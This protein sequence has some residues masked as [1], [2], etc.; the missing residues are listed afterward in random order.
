[1]SVGTWVLFLSPEKSCV[2][3][4]PFHFSKRAASPGHFRFLKSRSSS[5]GGTIDNSPGRQ[6][7]EF[8]D[9]VSEAPVGATQSAMRVWCAL[10]WFPGS[11]LGT[12]LI[13]RLGL[14]PRRSLGGRAFPGGSLGTRRVHVRFQAGAWE[15]EGCTCVS[16]RVPG[17]ETGARAFPGG[18]L[19]HVHPMP[20]AKWSCTWTVQ[21]VVGEK[22]LASRF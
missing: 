9:K 3:C 22:R 10:V 5:P 13:Y 2:R 16:R 7:W 6:P 4:V 20:T 14:K 21:S 18:C 11:R 15:R 1:M 8:E 19:P 12:S 17:N